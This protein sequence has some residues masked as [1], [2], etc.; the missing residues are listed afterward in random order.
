MV[1]PSAAPATGGKKVTLA[2]AGLTIILAIVVGLNLHEGGRRYVP[3]WDA[4]GHVWTVCNGITGKDVVPGRH[5]T[6]AE[7]ETL[8]VAYVRK[9]LTNMGHCATGTFTFTEIKA[10]GDFAYNVGTA[11]FCNSTA[12]RLLN[13]GENRRACDEIPKWRF[14][15]KKDCA[16][17]A[18]KCGGIVT[19]RA[20]EYGMC[21]GDG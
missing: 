10:W 5:Y 9:M 8:E 2:S 12:V 17:K 21:V 16:I 4:L 11:N 20:W 19:R 6:D 14:I 7:C 3:Y 1:T 13:A 18:N 15:N